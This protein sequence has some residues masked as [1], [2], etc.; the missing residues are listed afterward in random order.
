[1]SLLLSNETDISTDRLGIT[2]FR[3]VYHA[4]NLAEASTG[5]PSPLLDLPLIE[6]Q[7]KQ[8]PSGLYDVVF[9]YEGV[10]PGQ[11]QNID[12]Y[13]L[14]GTS[15]EESIENHPRI[16]KL[17]KLY[18]GDASK[19]PIDWPETLVS[20]NGTVVNNPLYG[21]TSY[22]V[23]G[24]VW[25]RNWVSNSFPDSIVTNIGK[26]EIP[27]NA[28]NRSLPTLPGLRNW[29]KMR[30]IGRWRGNIWQITESWM[31]SDEGGWN[32]D[33]YEAVETSSNMLAVL[34]SNNVTYVGSLDAVFG[35]S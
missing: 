15:G 32:T 23:A 18:G 33:V 7:A 3:P 27:P 9:L 12:Y 25:T 30:G 16:A 35:G 20:N 13:E 1:M 21:Y 24:L 14:E 34:G 31:L 4:A 10:L 19:S 8:L 28:G 11:K 2:T 6:R 17:I 22:Y 29:L 5:I 26:I